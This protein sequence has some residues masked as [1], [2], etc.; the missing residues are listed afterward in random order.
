VSR[1][2]VVF[3]SAARVLDIGRFDHGDVIPMA[4]SALHEAP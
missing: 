2:L 1:K 4:G 3:L